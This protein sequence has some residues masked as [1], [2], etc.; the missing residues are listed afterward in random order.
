MSVGIHKVGIIFY[1]VGH[2]YLIELF[3]IININIASAAERYKRI[4]IKKVSA[5]EKWFSVLE[6]PEVK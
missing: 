2:I 5:E 1:L 4:A 3:F 6:R